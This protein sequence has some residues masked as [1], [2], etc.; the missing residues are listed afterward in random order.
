MAGYP[1]DYTEI[2]RLMRNTLLDMQV[3]RDIIRKAGLIPGD[4]GGGGGGAND[5]TARSGYRSVLTPPP[6]DSMEVVYEEQTTVPYY[7]DQVLPTGTT[8][9]AQT[10]S[11]N[12][13]VQ[14]EQTGFYRVHA[15]MSV[16]IS[17]IDIPWITQIFACARDA[18]FNLQRYVLLDEQFFPSEPRGPIEIGDPLDPNYFFT[19]QWWTNHVPQMNGQNV[20]GVNAGEVITTDLLIHFLGDPTD[21]SLIYAGLSV[22]LGG[23]VDH[24]E[25]IE[26]LNP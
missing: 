11:P 25:W 2:L 20:I 13:A 12:T 24:R 6:D 7:A 10:L 4:T 16:F 3:A 1:T 15:S 23:I 26:L 21:T 5:L 17:E 18:D 9:L 19:E 8:H 14:I 22:I